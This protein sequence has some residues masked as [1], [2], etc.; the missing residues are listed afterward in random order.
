MGL[1]ADKSSG[2]FP[3]STRVFPKRPDLEQ[4]IVP[5]RYRLIYEKQQMCPCRQINDRQA[6]AAPQCTKDQVGKEASGATDDANPSSQEFQKR[7][8]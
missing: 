7:T 8:L 6:V 5:T 1:D 2:P 4:R 3:I